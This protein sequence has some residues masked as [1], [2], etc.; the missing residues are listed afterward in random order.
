MRGLRPWNAIQ[1]DTITARKVAIAPATCPIALTIV[2]Q[3]SVL[4]MLPPMAF[5]HGG[6][7]GGNRLP[8]KAV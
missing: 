7:L 1:S 8:V 6:K 5:L 2:Q 4:H 3:S